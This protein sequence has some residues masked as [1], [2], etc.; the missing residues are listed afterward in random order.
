[1]PLEVKTGR[2]G[3]AGERG[4]VGRGGRE[5]AGSRKPERSKGK[6]REKRRNE[7]RVAVVSPLRVSTGGGGFCGAV[8]PWLWL[9]ACALLRVCMRIPSPPPFRWTH[10]ETLINP[11]AGITR[12]FYVK[13]KETEKDF[14]LFKTRPPH[15]QI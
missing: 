1:M 15:T 10:L 4:E 6:R 12:G 14:I 5:G 11:R 8:A 9:M 2:H 3:G 13:P 7:R